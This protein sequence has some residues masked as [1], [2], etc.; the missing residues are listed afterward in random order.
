[1]RILLTALLTALAW[2]AG[3]PGSADDD[4]DDDDSAGEADDDS[5]DDD[6]AAAPGGFRFEAA[7]TATGG[8]GP[9]TADVTVQWTML[10]DTSADEP[11]ELCAYTYSFAAEY[12]EIVPGQGDDYYPYIDAVVS[13]TSGEMTESDCSS[14]WDEQFAPIADPLAYMEWWLSPIA[15]ISCDLIDSIPNLAATDYFEDPWDLGLSDASLSSWCNEFGPMVEQT[16]DTGPMEG[17]WLRPSSTAWGDYDIGLSYFDAPN[18]DI[19]SLGE[20]DAWSAMG[21]VYAHPDNPHEP[22]DG[23]EGDYVTDIIWVWSYEPPE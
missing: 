22:I 4:V 23:L 20:F 21:F 14:E 1:M 10:D 18:G 19:G 16:G 15:V 3:C 6:S 8:I 5:A 11:I 7:F 13:F 2:A 17:V 12:P 9:G